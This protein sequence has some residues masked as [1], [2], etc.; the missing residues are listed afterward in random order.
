MV[1]VILQVVIL[2]DHL[3]L[4]FAIVEFVDAY[5]HQTRFY[6]CLQLVSEFLKN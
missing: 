6:I 1:A 4:Q 2:A 3:Q 5:I